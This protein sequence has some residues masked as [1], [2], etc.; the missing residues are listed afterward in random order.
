[1]GSLA[2]LCGLDAA[3]PLVDRGLG[4][5]EVGATAYAPAHPPY[6]LAVRGKPTATQ[7][8]FTAAADL[9]TI[10]PGLSGLP[11]GGT[12]LCYVDLPGDFV[13]TFKHAF[14]IF[15]ARTGILSEGGLPN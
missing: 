10:I 11:P 15:D 5:G 2:G 8:R 1:M 13:E 7:A 9:I 4:R 14:E 3:D 6:Q 12:A